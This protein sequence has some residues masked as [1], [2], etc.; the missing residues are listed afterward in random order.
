M[1]DQQRLQRAI[2]E[3]VTAH[4]PGS[5][6]KS[7]TAI[8]IAQKNAVHQFGT[9]ILFS[10]GDYSFAV[11]AGH[12]VKEAQRR[13]KTLALS[14]AAGSFVAVPGQWLASSE[15][16]YRTDTDPFDIA[17]H[18]LPQDTVDRLSGKAFLRFDDI[19]FGSQPATAVYTLFGFPAVLTK[20]STSDA[21]KLLLR[22]FQYTTFA[23][24]RETDGLAEYQERFHLLL[25]A[26]LGH[27]SAGDGSPAQFRDRQGNHVP[28]PKGLGGISGCSVWRI[29][30]LNTAID[31]WGRERARNVAVQTSVYHG[32][33]AI[34]AT[35]W[36]AVRTLLHEAFPE[37]RPSMRLW[38]PR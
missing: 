36:I 20:S 26:Q 28:F 35:R 14:S 24:D 17:V 22:P 12:V 34:K 10:V 19:E 13:G 31:D 16:Q 37:V 25:D 11:T 38:R 29:G 7:A 8:V 2:N 5:A 33:Q 3:K 30:D 15:G 27:S 23:Y 4:I 9:A 1:N 21:D 18:K 6:W 32:S